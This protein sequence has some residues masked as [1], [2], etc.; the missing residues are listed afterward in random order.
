MRGAASPLSSNDVTATPF[1]PWGSPGEG[2]SRS[3]RKTSVSHLRAVTAASAADFPA[4]VASHSRARGSW[5]WATHAPIKD[6]A[7]PSSPSL[8]LLSP[9]QATDPTLASL[10][11]VS[12]SPSLSLLSPLPSPP[13]SADDAAFP[14]HVIPVV[15]ISGTSVPGASVGIPVLVGIPVPVGGGGIH[16]PSMG[17]PT[18]H[19]PSRGRTRKSTGRSVAPALS[20]R[21]PAN[22]NPSTV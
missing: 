6:P 16:A 20:W 5:G 18:A 14:I 4:A 8:L 10:S 11:S 13:T 15:D 22:K 3:C 7:P 9:T 2:T 19:T 1:F 17:S 21:P 12:P